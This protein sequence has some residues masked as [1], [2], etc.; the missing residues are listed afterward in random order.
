MNKD[1]IIKYLNT[2][3]SERLRVSKIKSTNFIIKRVYDSSTHPKSRFKHITQK[4]GFADIKIIK[5]IFEGY[6]RSSSENHNVEGYSG[7][8][9][10]YTSHFHMTIYFDVYSEWLRNEKLISIGI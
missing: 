8:W 9:F 4:Y 3:R 7:D 1:L 10:A 5:V 2:E 6:Y